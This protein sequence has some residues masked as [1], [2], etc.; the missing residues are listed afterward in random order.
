VIVYLAQTASLGVTFDG[1]ADNAGV[2]QG[3]SDSDWAVGHSTSGWMLFLAGA[4]VVY[5][6][7]RQPC[8]AL[9]STEAEIIAAS[10]CAVQIQHAVVL[11]RELGLCAEEPVKLHVDNTGTVAL[12]RDRKSCH[13]SRHV[14]R[15]YFKVRE[16]AAEGVLSVDYVGTHENTSDVL[17]KV[18]PV[19][20]HWKHAGRALNL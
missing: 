10:A 14:D 20:A 12:A 8:I 15:R 3:M 6:S 13:K 5:S 17:T 1:S 4:A 11:M 16:L 2:L 7:K 18:L 19:D 9:S